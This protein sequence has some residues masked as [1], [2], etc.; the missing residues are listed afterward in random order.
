MHFCMTFDISGRGDVEKAGAR[1][2][3]SQVKAEH[4]GALYDF[5]EDSWVS[6]WKAIDPCMRV[7]LKENDMKQE[8]IATRCAAVIDLFLQLSTIP[9]CLSRRRGSS[10][11][12]S[13][14]E[15]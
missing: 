7:L 15:P 12:S 14:P 10:I 8:W 1:R 9:I 13:S 2:A 11:A 6:E 4:L 5:I 3:L